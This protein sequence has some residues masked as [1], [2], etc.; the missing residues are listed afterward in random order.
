MLIILRPQTLNVCIFHR[1]TL[2]C[3]TDLTRSDWCHPWGFFNHAYSVRDEEGNLQRKI[4]GPA[5]SF[6]GM[7]YVGFRSPTLLDH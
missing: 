7:W 2:C 3:F 6:L 1:E 4:E 5:G